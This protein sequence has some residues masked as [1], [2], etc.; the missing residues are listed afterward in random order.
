MLWRACRRDGQV[1]VS[2]YHKL[3]DLVDGRFAAW[4]MPDGMRGRGLGRESNSAI[5]VP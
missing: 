4:G 5:P 3:D 1:G 2:K